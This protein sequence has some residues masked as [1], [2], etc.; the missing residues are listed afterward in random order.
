MEHDDPICRVCGER[1]SA[2]VATAKG[3]LTHPREA[4]GEGEY[5]LVAAGTYGAIT[6]GDDDT[7]WERYEFRPTSKGDSP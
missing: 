7:P 3:P 1:K 4:K 2:H 6:P 5:V